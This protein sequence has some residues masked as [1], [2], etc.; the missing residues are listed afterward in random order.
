MRVVLFLVLFIFGLYDRCY[1]GG[2]AIFEIDESAIKNTNLVGVWVLARV[3][4][5]S[6]FA[7][8]RFRYILFQVPQHKGS[9]T[10]DKGVQ[11]CKKIKDHHLVPLLAF[12][13]QRFHFMLDNRGDLPEG[14]ILIVQDLLVFEAKLVEQ[15]L[16]F[17]DRFFDLCE[18]EL[19]FV[20]VVKCVGCKDHSDLVVVVE[21]SVALLFS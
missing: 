8:K 10:L 21:E 19:R 9:L 2:F 20:V 11:T 13:K 12:F 16:K 14:G 1:F 4:S 15:I 5:D 6:G 3:G 18:V 17:D 7:W